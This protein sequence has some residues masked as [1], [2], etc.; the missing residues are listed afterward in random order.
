MPECCCRGA[1]AGNPGVSAVNERIRAVSL[2]SVERD[3]L[4]QMFPGDRWFSKPEGC[5]AECMVP[6]LE[7]SRISHTLGQVE[8]LLGELANFLELR[9]HQVKRPQSP[10]HRKELGRLPDPSAE[11]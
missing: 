11:L 5:S 2:G 10:Q 6:Q 8:E 7:E 9:P 4:V 3:T 1:K